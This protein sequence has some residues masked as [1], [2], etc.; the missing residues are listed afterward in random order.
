MAEE[1][2]AVFII[3]KPMPTKKRADGTCCVMMVKPPM[4]LAIPPIIKLKM[5]A[6]KLKAKSASVTIKPNVNAPTAISSGM[7]IGEANMANTINKRQKAL[8]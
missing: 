1:N 8:F 4:I 6:K 2:V 7:A 5:N 3:V